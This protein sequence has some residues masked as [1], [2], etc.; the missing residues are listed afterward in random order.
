MQGIITSISYYGGN[1]AEVEVVEP[2]QEGDHG[3]QQGPA[4]HH[5][6]GIESTHAR[7]WWAWL[8]PPAPP[9][10]RHVGPIRQR[11]RLQPSNT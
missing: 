10:L 2:F 5:R 11:D 1:I 6:H 7:R 9:R 4:R 3:F 8:C